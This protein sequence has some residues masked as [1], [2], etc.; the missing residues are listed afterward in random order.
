VR[1]EA[2]VSGYGLE[3]GAIYALGAPLRDAIERDG[4]AVLKL[5]LAPDLGGDT[6]AARLARPRGGQSTSTFLRKAAGLTPVVIGLLR[7]AFGGA[8]PDDLAAAIKAAPVTLTAPRGLE[9]AISTAGGVA[10]S[11]VDEHLMLKAIPNVFVAGEM[12]DWEAPT[13]GYLLQAC[14]AS[15]VAAAEGCADRARSRLS[16]NPRGSISPGP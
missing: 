16:A 2:V 10:W 3:G 11:A 5:D 9:R 8:L 7:E 4:K 14:F 12:L 1:G 13:G 15:G 6:L